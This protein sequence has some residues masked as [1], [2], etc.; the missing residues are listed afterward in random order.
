MSRS[1]SP[2]TA[3]RL[4]GAALLL[5]PAVLPFASCS[6]AERD[7]NGGQ[8]GG[9][10]TSTTS[11]SMTCDPGSTASCYSGPMG[12][13]GVGV[14]APGLQ[15]CNPEG[16]GYGPCEGEVLP[17]T[18][19]CAAPQD[20]DCDGTAQPC[21]LTTLW[22]RGF[23]G[24]FYF[25]FPNVATDAQ[26]NVLFAGAFF[27]QLDLG[28]GEVLTAPTG[29]I[30][31][32]LVKLSPVGEIL[33]TRHFGGVGSQYIRGLGTDATGGVLVAGGF[34]EQL[35]FGNG[36]VTSVQ[37]SEDVFVARFNPDGTPDWRRIFGG[38]GNDNAFQLAVDPA[39]RPVVVGSFSDTVNFGT[40]PI[41]A[42]SGS[43]TFIVK[44]A[45]GGSPTIFA[46]AFASVMGS[47]SAAGVAADSLGNTVMT[48]YFSQQIDFGSGLLTSAGGNDA[49]LTRL[50]ST[51]SALSAVRYGD[52]LSDQG[53][54]VAVGAGDSVVVGGDFRGIVDFGGGPLACVGDANLFL[55]SYAA[56]GEHRWSMRLGEGEG[57]D[58]MM[59]VTIDAE[60]N[61]LVTGWFNTEL[62]FGA[63]TLQVTGTPGSDVDIF[64]AKLGPMGE[65]LASR[66]FGTM[67]GDGGF[68]VEV[69]PTGAPIIS[70]ISTGGEAIDLGTGPLPVSGQLA[71]FIVAKLAP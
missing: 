52:T 60:A 4:A 9:T 23:P 54:D 59:A 16:T 27:E 13:E 56:T 44:V 14:C 66:S 62:R 19:D 68:D 6:P 45:A 1:I 47:E 55:A 42:T 12:T 25:I 49:F 71:T 39:G 28:N 30:D 3:A 21:P 20:E 37:G 43:N 51:G 26:G 65:P 7:F 70:G 58:H 29:D 24:G 48:G 57:T 17:G 50:S 2:R 34:S 53:F 22:A 63:D 64:V 11:T 33:W 61:T 40:G 8:A 41:T 69:D 10:T 46:R 18:E 67:G 15:V 35:D 31:A 38:P 32:F 5:L 36:P